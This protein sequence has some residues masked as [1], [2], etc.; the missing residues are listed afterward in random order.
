M[1]FPQSLRAVPP[2]A[3]QPSPPTP[4]I[5][6]PT[7]PLFPQT[8]DERDYQPNTNLHSLP[9]PHPPLTKL[10]TRSSSHSHSNPHHRSQSEFGTAASPNS[11]H[12][13]SSRLSANNSPSSD[14]GSAN[15][16]ISPSSRSPG[17][18]RSR[19]GRH[20][21]FSPDLPNKDALY[22]FS[23]FSSYMRSP[24]EGSDGVR[25]E[26]FK[27]TIR[28]LDHARALASN[29]SSN[30]HILHLKYRF[31]GQTNTFR[32]PY[33]SG[34]Y[35][36]P[37]N[38][39]DSIGRLRN[40]VPQPFSVLHDPVVKIDYMENGVFEPLPAQAVFSHIAKICQPPPRIIV[41]SYVY[42]KVIENHLA[43]LSTWALTSSPPSYIF[44]P[45]ETRIREPQPL[46][47][48]LHH[49]I[50]MSMY[51]W[52][53]DG[54]ALTPSTGDSFALTT[55]SGAG[56]PSYRL[57]PT[58]PYQ[59]PFSAKVRKRFAAQA[60]LHA[61]RASQTAGIAQGGARGEVQDSA[62]EDDEKEDDVSPILI[63]RRI[64]G[65]ESP[66][67]IVDRYYARSQA[68]KLMRQ[69]PVDPI[70]SLTV[71][72][73]SPPTRPLS[74][75]PH[76]HHQ[77]LTQLTL[78]TNARAGMKRVKSEYSIRSPS[79]SN[80]PPAHPP[81]VD[82]I[83]LW[84]LA[85]GVGVL[86]GSTSASIGIKLTDF[87]A[88][89]LVGEGGE[90]E[91]K[92]LSREFRRS[93][94]RDLGIKTSPLNV[95]EVAVDPMSINMGL[96]ILE[97]PISRPSS[98]APTPIG[99]PGKSD[100]ANPIEN[101]LSPPEEGRAKPKIPI[102]HLTPPDPRVKSLGRQRVN[103]SHSSQN[104]SWPAPISR[105]PGWRKGRKEMMED[106]LDEM[107]LGYAAEQVENQELDKIA[108][109]IDE[110]TVDAESIRQPRKLAGAGESEKSGG[111]ID[112]L[113]PIEYDEKEV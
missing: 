1:P 43:S 64:S 59:N 46:H 88:I 56:P 81:P 109:K 33:F 49:A 91:S 27:D 42:S 22:L 2:L 111:L 58:S 84:H 69:Y 113:M 106:T 95:T 18:Q 54:S 10:D 28:L 20:F 112:L 35:Q 7:A 89:N 98:T 11:A 97:Q 21:P 94:V 55:G 86:H 100:N 102:A 80:P 105:V 92:A 70:A 65:A 61:R 47:V 62:L 12:S 50:P 76:P 63:T 39:R 25:A 30:V 31:Q 52:P 85:P 90:I 74:A 83:P 23:N 26:D 19:S 79:N 37:L 103:L 38:Y 71:I 29:P 96:A 78:A 15:N 82:R 4:A 93:E 3:I 108:R 77:P 45:L 107:D 110:M 16:L 101:R 36:L 67:D 8:V 72:S 14:S 32:S 87:S 17:T 24:N 53:V 48:A 6:P 68:D 44:S 13:T 40:P 9:L 51:A 60:L 34:D 57:T 75:Q 41:I 5:V 73:S 104:Q 66:T 99:I